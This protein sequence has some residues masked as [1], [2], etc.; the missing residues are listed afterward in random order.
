M[1]LE[2]HYLRK[3]TH[4]TFCSLKISSKSFEKRSEEGLKIGLMTL[5]ENSSSSCLPWTE[6]HGAAWLWAHTIWLLCYGQ[7]STTYGKV[8]YLCLSSCLK[9][10]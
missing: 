2:S 7:K 8:L 5:S 4:L 9:E 10:R 1:T 6:G 3:I